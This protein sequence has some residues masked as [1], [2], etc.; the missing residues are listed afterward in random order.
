MI[1][2]N[3]QARGPALAALIA[4]LLAS[5]AF[6]QEAIVSP[7]IVGV[8]DGDTVKALVSDNELLRVRLG[9]D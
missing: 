8:A 9:L 5:A 7:R 1:R 2:C 6:G 4:F 3:F